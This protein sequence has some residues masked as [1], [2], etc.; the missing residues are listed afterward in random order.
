M[1]I[2]RLDE[3]ESFFP[4]ITPMVDIVLLVL[5]FF[6]VT[7]TYSSVPKKLDV[8]LPQAGATDGQISTEVRLFLA[9]DGRIRLKG[10]WLEEGELLSALN[11]LKK[12]VDKPVLLISADARSRHQR[13][14]DIITRAKQAGI[15]D[16]GFEITLKRGK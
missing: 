3:S 5:I 15:S 7:A 8:Q 6:L 4:K 14:V 11:R 16:F 2:Y 10:K 9:A 12:T 1:E 13:L